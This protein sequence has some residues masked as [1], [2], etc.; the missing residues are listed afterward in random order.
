VSNDPCKGCWWIEGGRCFNDG[1]APLYGLEKAP[2]D[3][4]IFSGKN[5]FA[6]DDQHITNCMEVSGR[7]SKA[8]VLSNVFAK[9]KADG[10]QVAYNGNDQ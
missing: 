1:L 3:A 6:T 4:P 8:D 2:R 7:K 9:L 10:I 5:G